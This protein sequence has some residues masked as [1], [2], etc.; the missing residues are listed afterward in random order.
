MFERKHKH[1]H[2]A[3]EQTQTKWKK[4]MMKNKHGKEQTADKR[5]KLRTMHEIAVP[6]TKISTM[7]G[8]M[9]H[10]V[11]DATGPDDKVRTSGENKLYDLKQP[12]NLFS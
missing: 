12:F 9:L 7:T 4:E 3:D 1:A 6:P 8:K 5:E 2:D 10:T 11:N